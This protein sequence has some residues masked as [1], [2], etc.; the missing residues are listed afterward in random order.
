[1]AGREE[2]IEVKEGS[3]RTHLP[4]YE[5]CPICE[6]SALVIF[7]HKKANA[8]VAEGRLR[9]QDVDV[10]IVQGCE[11]CSETLVVLTVPQ[12]ISYFD[13]IACGVYVV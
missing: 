6:D 8:T 11:S 9:T 1:M 13:Q 5:T 4:F 7:E 3:A 12:F 2:P 10:Q